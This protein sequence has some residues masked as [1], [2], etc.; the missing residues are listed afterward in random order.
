MIGP[1]M[2]AWNAKILTGYLTIQSNLFAVLLKQSLWHWRCTMML[3]WSYAWQYW[4]SSRKLQTQTRRSSTGV[5]RVS[6]SS[7]WS[8]SKTSSVVLLWFTLIWMN[9]FL[10]GVDADNG[11]RGQRRVLA[12]N[13]LRH[14][15]P[16]HCQVKPT[17]YNHVRYWRTA[18]AEDWF[19]FTTLLHFISDSS[20]HS[21]YCPWVF[22]KDFEGIWGV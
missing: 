9:W 21:P 3:L 4:N 2:S 14:R 13:R 18:I 10:A 5:S 12:R 15:Y 16:K 20:I 7:P 19:F 1:W 8:S 22:L 17:E 6:S 11:G